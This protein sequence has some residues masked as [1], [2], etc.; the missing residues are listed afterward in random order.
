[1]KKILY[2]LLIIL[3]LL[4]SC[5]TQNDNSEKSVISFYLTDAPDENIS[6]A[7]INI[8]EINLSSDATKIILLR[9][10]NINFLTLSGTL[11]IM[12]RIEV[13]D[14]NL[15]K[16]SKI[17]ITLDSTIDIGSK[18]I[19]ITSTEITLKL[20]TSE[21]YPGRDYNVIVDLDL[22]TSLSGDTNFTP[23]FRLW[24][25]ADSNADY[26]NVSGYVF[27]DIQSQTPKPH[28]TVLITDTN[29]STILY[30]TLSNSNGEYRFN[31]IKLDLT[32]NYKI[33][34]AYSGIN[35]DSNSLDFS[36]YIITDSATTLDTNKE[37]INLYIGEGQ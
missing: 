5:I 11:L 25:I 33:A 17:N 12:K 6:K 2:L 14:E 1:M 8:K 31:K 28:R 7:E 37:E 30:S 18:K 16:N 13:I 10:E 4:A 36:S 19:T 26:K 9:N 24:M 3:L 15:L 32:K 23:N 34:V 20:D 27:D 22:G 21:F 35:I 29:Y